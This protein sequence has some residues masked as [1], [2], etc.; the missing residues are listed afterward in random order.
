MAALGRL[1]VPPPEMS[2]RNFGYAFGSTTVTVGSCES[3]LKLCELAK[4]TR[5]ATSSSS[6]YGESIAAFIV[7]VVTD[8]TGFDQVD[9]CADGHGIKFPWINGITCRKR[10]R[11]AATRGMSEDVGAVLLTC[12]LDIKANRFDSFNASLL[13]PDAR[14]MF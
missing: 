9:I 11:G 13:N 6:D 10:E 14:L 5:F 7:Y 1:T 3:H 2:R 12:L 8:Q 4:L